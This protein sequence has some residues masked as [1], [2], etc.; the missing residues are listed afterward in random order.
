[1]INR[2]IHFLAWLM[3]MAA[4]VL[5]ALVVLITVI[6]VGGFILN[7]IVRPFGGTVSGLPGYE[8]AVSVFVGMAVFF[9]LPYCQLSRGHVSVDLFTSRMSPRSLRMLTR[10][11]DLVMAIA[12]GFFT[13]M[14]VSGLFEYRD[15]GVRTPVLGWPVWPFI[16][17]GIVALALWCV[18]A[19]ALALDPSMARS[20]LDAEPAPAGDGGGG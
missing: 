9:I 3:A 12:A 5:F 6:N 20:D 4:G 18:T 7:T 15:D 17:P 2:T 19:F 1:M 14:L 8:D 11:T 10:S 13:I 16:I